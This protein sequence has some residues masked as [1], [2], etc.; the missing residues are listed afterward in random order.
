MKPL[1]QFQDGMK[2]MTQFQD[3]MKPLT[4]FQDGMKLMPF[5]SGGGAGMKGQEVPV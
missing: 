5:S 2:L 4:Q 1:T 3:G